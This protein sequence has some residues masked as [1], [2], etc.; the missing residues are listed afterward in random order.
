MPMSRS[1]WTL[2]IVPMDPAPR[3]MAD[4]PLC[5]R[6]ALQDIDDALEYIDDG[7]G[8]GDTNVRVGRFST[9]A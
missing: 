8:S 7:L 9:A 1:T 6:D 4:E 3:R 2:D 5:I